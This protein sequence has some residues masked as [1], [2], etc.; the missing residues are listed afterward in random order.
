[1][2]GIFTDGGFNGGVQANT[3]TTLKA[4]IAITQVITIIVLFH[5]SKHCFSPPLVN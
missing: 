3:G 1:M 5:F 2:S 4:P